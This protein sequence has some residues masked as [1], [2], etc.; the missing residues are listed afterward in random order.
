M[1]TDITFVSAGFVRILQ[2]NCSIVEAD[3]FKLF[4]GDIKLHIKFSSR[5][6]EGHQLIK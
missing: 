1:E 3:L 6:I 5:L 4:A 2:L